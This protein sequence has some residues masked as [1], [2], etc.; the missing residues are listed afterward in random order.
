MTTEP[1]A[2]TSSRAAATPPTRPVPVLEATAA[3]DFLRDAMGSLDHTSPAYQYADL[4]ARLLGGDLT[5]DQAMAI[6]DSDTTEEQ[7]A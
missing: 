3:F 5:Y 7:Q 1:T 6:A 4:A 2:R